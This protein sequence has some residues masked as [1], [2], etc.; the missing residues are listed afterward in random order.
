MTLAF[1]HLGDGPEGRQVSRWQLGDPS[2]Y[3]EEPRV[4]KEYWSWNPEHPA[5]LEFV[6]E[7]FPSYTRLAV[8]YARS[9]EEEGVT[10]FSLGTETDGL[11]RTRQ[12]GSS[13]WTTG[14]YDELPEMVESMRAVYSGSITCDMVW[15]SPTKPMFAYLFDLWEDLGLD[16][17]G[18][19][20]Y[21]HLG[22]PRSAE[23]LPATED[24]LFNAWRT[25]FRDFLAP[26]A[27]ANPGLPILFLEFGYTDAVG[28]ACGPNRM[29][30]S[31]KVFI[32]RGENGLDDGE[33]EQPHI[34]ASRFRAL[35]EF[36]DVLD[37]PFLWGDM[38]ATDRPL[39]GN[40]TSDT[41]AP[42]IQQELAQQ[43]VSDAFAALSVQ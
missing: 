4:W 31:T 27:S 19:S 28:S 22:E 11:F 33:E 38:V 16:A 21:V 40:R 34:C 30:Y 17:I 7:F 25:R 43:V 6:D 23:A 12:T 41:F 18:I 35:Q 24:E 20:A 32:D 36:P 5:H 42:S 9:C 14:F 2:I 3:E 26:F 1:E 29:E 39:T 37:G 10:L 8:R 15:A 13:Y